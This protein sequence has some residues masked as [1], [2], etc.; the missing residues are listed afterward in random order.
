MLQGVKVGSVI[1]LRRNAALV[2]KDKLEYIIIEVTKTKGARLTGR[3]L[4]TLEERTF[5]DEGHKLTDCTPT[6]GGFPRINVWGYAYIAT[7]SPEEVCTHLEQR[8]AILEQQAADA[9][10]HAD[11]Y[12]ADTAALLKKRRRRTRKTQ[13]LAA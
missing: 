8:L 12:K 7:L 5:E 1:R 4:Y 6:K 10:A 13:K 11:R 3:D 2:L 9:R